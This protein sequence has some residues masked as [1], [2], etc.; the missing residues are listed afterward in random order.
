MSLPAFASIDDLRDRGVTIATDVTSTV[1]DETRAQ[2]MLDD[3]SALIRSVAG[4]TWVTDDAL[5]ADLPAIVVTV[6]CA[7]ARRAYE[8]PKNIRSSNIDGY[9][10]VIAGDV[11]GGVEL[12]EDERKLVRDAASI[13]GTLAGL[14]P[15][16]TTRGPLETAGPCDQWDAPVLLPTD[17]ASSEAIAWLDPSEL[18]LP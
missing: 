17:G 6:C 7:A 1:D 11:V 9:S 10:D 2:A 4:K 15:L 13:G 16:G 18:P 12:T 3:V 8:N 14:W 5:D